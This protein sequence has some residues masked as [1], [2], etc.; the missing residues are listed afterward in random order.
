[1]SKMIPRTGP[2]AASVDMDGALDEVEDA[3][4]ERE[5]WCIRDGEDFVFMDDI[6]PLPPPRK[7]STATA[8]APITI[9]LI[10]LLQKE[11]DM[12]RR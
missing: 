11:D 4:D 1:M 9:A 5:V 10:I 6:V 2:S 7:P 12:S 3:V 8:A